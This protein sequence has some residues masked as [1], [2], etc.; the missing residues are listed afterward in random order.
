M[1]YLTD[2]DPDTNSEFI[3]SNNTHCIVCDKQA[4]PSCH[5]H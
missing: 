2:F 5:L 4:T 1:N 3:T